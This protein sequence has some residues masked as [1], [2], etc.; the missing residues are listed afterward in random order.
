MDWHNKTGKLAVFNGAE[1]AFEIR[2][3]PLSEPGK[4]DVLLKMRISGICG[5]DIHIAKGRLALPE[6]IV[7]GHECSG[8]ILALGENSQKDGLGQDLAVGDQVI[9]CVAIPCGK[10]VNCVAGETASC[11][12]F[13]V[14]YLKQADETPYFNGGFGEYLYSPA[15]NLVK[16]PAG[17]SFE[18]ASAFP[19][20]GPT[21]IRAF[22]YGGGLKPGELVVV[23]GSGPLGLFATAWAVSAGCKVIVIGSGKPQSRVDLALKLGAEKVLD[24]REINEEERL[25]IITQRATELGCGNGADVVIETSGAPSAVPEGMNLL[26]TRGRYIVPGQYSASGGINIQPQMITFKA[27][28]IIGS[29]QYTLADIK[30][31]LDF[32]AENKKVAEIFEACLTGK[33]RLEEI[34]EAFSDI[35]AGKHLKGV[36]TA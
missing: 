20:A 34:N 9:A 33:Y 22:T 3:Y 19:C 4:D 12:N 17:V 31:Y 36:I 5:T 25:K 26:R 1:K 27:L 2:E 6:G 28:R 8:D 11:L 10:C 32:I 15:V 13:G 35:T 30:T 16:I 29:G 7:I 23:Q 18:A 21:V 24:Y 14:T